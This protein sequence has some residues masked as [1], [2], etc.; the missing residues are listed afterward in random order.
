M[1]AALTPREREV[2]ALV[3]EGMSRKEIGTALGI[4][5]ETVRGHLTNINTKLGTR[6]M[7]DIVIHVARHH[8][9][10]FS[11]NPPIN[12]DLTLYG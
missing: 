12:A 6:S 2:I 5:L 10:T 4:S 11:R 3:C 8:P 9:G 1:A 7:V